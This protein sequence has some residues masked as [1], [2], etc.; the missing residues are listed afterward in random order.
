[1]TAVTTTDQ[2]VRAAEA[3]RNAGGYSELIRLEAE[4]RAAGGPGQV[5]RNPETGRLSFQVNGQNGR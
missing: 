2:Q 5:V 1:M 3:A 4:R